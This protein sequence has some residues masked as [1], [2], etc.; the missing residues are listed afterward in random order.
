[1]CCGGCRC[2][3]VLQPDPQVLFGML[4]G[5]CLSLFPWACV[6]GV[7]VL[8]I[9]HNYVPITV[10][11]TSPTHWR[12]RQLCKRYRGPP[13]AH[14]RRQTELR[15]LSISHERV[16]SDG[17]EWRRAGRLKC[18]WPTENGTPGTMLWRKLHTA[19]VSIQASDTLSTL[20]SLCVSNL[21]LTFSLTPLQRSL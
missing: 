2:I 21:R 19:V 8:T 14:N 17:F 18:S 6:N 10:R 12:R 9:R 4:P 3:Q 5:A 11:P 15:W 1:M 20:R 13:H 7:T 16:S